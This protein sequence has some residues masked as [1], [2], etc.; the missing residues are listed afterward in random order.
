MT[1]F[2]I[3]DSLSKLAQQQTEKQLDSSQDKPFSEMTTDEKI[4]MANQII[5]SQQASGLPAALDPEIAD[6]IGAMEEPSMGLDDA[7]NSANMD[8]GE[9]YGN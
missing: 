4:A 6:F 3:T 8:A 5:A 9:D 1:N 7:I 2:S